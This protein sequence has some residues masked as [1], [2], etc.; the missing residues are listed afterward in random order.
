MQSL[1]EK[2][3]QFKHTIAVGDGYPR[4]YKTRINAYM[5][6]FNSG[7]FNAYQDDDFVE[8]RQQANDMLETY[9]KFIKRDLR[10]AIIM[11]AKNI[12][13]WKGQIEYERLVYGKDD[14]DTKIKQAKITVSEF[15]LD[16]L[17]K[18]RRENK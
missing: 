5:T 10:E 7:R 1:E 16:S 13:N 2:L 15:V 3:K 8:T 17:P 12:I 9:N 4:G 18:L 11:I 14:K 6:G